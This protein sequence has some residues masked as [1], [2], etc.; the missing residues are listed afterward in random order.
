MKNADHV[1][2]PV[3]IRLAESFTAKQE[4]EVRRILAEHQVV[5]TPTG[6]QAKL[7]IILADMPYGQK[8]KV[9]ALPF[10]AEV[11]DGSDGEIEF[12]AA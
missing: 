11:D 6:F 2:I 8:A 10:I 12:M 5:I 3:V 4:S 7:G 9:K 1:I